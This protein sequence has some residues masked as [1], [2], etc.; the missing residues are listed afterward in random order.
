MA[1]RRATVDKV[2]KVLS[3]Q[4]IGAEGTAEQTT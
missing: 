2:N 4:L 3:V 1:H